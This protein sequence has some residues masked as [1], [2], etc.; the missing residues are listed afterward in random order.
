MKT[1]AVF[2]V[3]IERN[4][5]EWEVRWHRHPSTNGY[6]WGW[7]EGAPG[8]VYWSNATEFGEHEALYVVRKHNALLEQERRNK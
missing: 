3:R 5:R 6:L 4:D 2:G 8:N 1:F 7:I